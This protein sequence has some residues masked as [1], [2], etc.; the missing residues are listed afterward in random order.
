MEQRD[1][2]HTGWS[3]ALI[4]AL[5]GLEWVWRRRVGLS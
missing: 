3:L 1:V 4:V 2:W 5:L